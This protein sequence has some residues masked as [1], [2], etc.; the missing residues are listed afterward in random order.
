MLLLLGKG[1]FDRNI[2]EINIPTFPFREY[3]FELE[4]DSYAR[5]GEGRIQPFAAIRE[6]PKV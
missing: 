5:K 2:L 6:D 4:Q 1:F 3:E